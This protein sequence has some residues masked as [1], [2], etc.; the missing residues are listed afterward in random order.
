MVNPGIDNWDGP[1]LKKEI[2]VDPWGKPY[3]YQSPGTH[4]SYDLLSYGGD[5]APG[6]EGEDQDVVSWK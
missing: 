1:Y 6:G 4:G 5:G 3:Q 2:P